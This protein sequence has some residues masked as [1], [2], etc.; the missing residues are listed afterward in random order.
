MKK[1]KGKYYKLAITCTFCLIFI[2]FIISSSNDDDYKSYRSKEEK[3]QL[4]DELRNADIDVETRCYQK[5]PVRYGLKCCEILLMAFVTILVVER[6]IS[7]TIRSVNF[8][9]FPQECS[10]WATKGCTRVVL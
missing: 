1:D 4:P 7:L 5:K 9:E 8:T 10:E 3:Y 6:L 2:H